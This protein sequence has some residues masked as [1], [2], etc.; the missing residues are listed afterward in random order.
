MSNFVVPPNF[1]LTETVMSQIARLPTK[2]RGP[3]MK[4]IAQIEWQKCANDIFYWL[5]AT[6]HYTSKKWPNGT[7]YVFT[8]DQHP[9]Y[10]CLQCKG[11]D[12]GITYPFNK[13]HEHLAFKHKIHTK[14]EQDLMGYFINLP[15]TRPFT[16]MEYFPPIIEAWLSN[17]YMAIEKSRDMMATW[18]TVIMYTWDTIFHHSRWNIF[19][20]EDSSKTEELC[21]RADFIYRHQPKFLREVHPAIYGKGTSKAGALKIETLE[22]AILGFPQGADQIRQYHPTGFFSDEAAF[23]TAA[24]ESFSAVKPSIQAGGR[25]TAVSSANPSFFQKIC[26]DTIHLASDFS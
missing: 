11:L 19:Q 7:P 6:Q 22:S 16:M 23:Q 26:R 2:Q 12:G 14:S 3:V 4:H 24:G 13:R 15:G 20:S 17:Q 1:K 10:Q 9:L 25:Y 18:L 21:A 8:N 5:D